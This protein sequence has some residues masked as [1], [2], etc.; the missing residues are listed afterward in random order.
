MKRAK[1]ENEQEKETQSNLLWWSTKDSTAVQS[2]FH[3]FISQKTISKKKDVDKFW[4]KYP[5]LNNRT[6]PQIKSKVQYLIKQS[7]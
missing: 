6:Y 1:N 4:K 7:K 3:L 5:K 2:F